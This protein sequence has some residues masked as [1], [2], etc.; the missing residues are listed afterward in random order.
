LNQLQFC[1]PCCA[2]KEQNQPR[3]GWDWR[4]DA[5]FIKF[6]RKQGQL[7]RA[8]GPSGFSF[9]ILAK[10]IHDPDCLQGT[11]AFAIANGD[12]SEHCRELLLACI[13]V[14]AKKSTPGVRPITLAHVFYR[15]AAARVIKLNRKPLEALYCTAQP[16]LS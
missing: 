8:P 13:L 15:I 9:A 5:E 11:A 7:G 14:A 2:L 3:S 12:L 10:V 1:K 6:V 16:T 4:R